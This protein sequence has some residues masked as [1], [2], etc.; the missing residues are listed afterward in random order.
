MNN[1]K[2]YNIFILLST[3]SR[4][5]PEIYSAV[6]LYKMDYSLKDILLFFAVLYFIGALTSTITIYLLNKIKP[7]YILIISSIIFSSSF[8]YMSIMP[9]N[10]KSLL[11]FSII[12]SIGSYTY[13]T[14]RHYYAIKA[15]E[16]N[17]K[18]NI[19]NILIFTNIAII[20]SS[21]LGGYIQSKLS[22]LYLAL[23]VA[24][25]SIISFI[26]LFKFETNTQKEKIK[27]P[28]IEKNKIKFFI[29]EQAKVINLS[30]EPLYLY[31][32]INNKITY[33]GVYNVI[34]GISSCIFIY[35]FTRRVNDKKYFKY[36]NIIF[37]LFLLLKLNIYNKYLILIIGL[38]EGLGIKMFEIVSSENIYNI[39]KNTNIRGYLLLVELIFCITRSI[40]CL[41]GY[42][43]NDI[44]I[45]LYLTIVLIFFIGFI[46]RDINRDC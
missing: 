39:K 16:E 10:N 1:I 40:F 26:P 7:K 11:I 6:L 22:T 42:L 33:V 27:Y 38:F 9:K 28:K 4:N 43:I 34:L 41:I 25:L 13:H 31:L 30:L 15:L 18:E 24:L 14:L 17:K 37:C 23:F 32:F 12:Y 45:I 19:G 29:L 5:I 8:Y 35:F 2:R 46:K 36:L 44:K 21:L 20:L 3:L